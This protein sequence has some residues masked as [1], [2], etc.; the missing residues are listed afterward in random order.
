M[1]RVISP[2]ESIPCRKPGKQ[3]VYSLWLGNNPSESVTSD[4][5]GIAL[6]FTEGQLVQLPSFLG[7]QLDSLSEVC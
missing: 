7:F 2:A 3:G 1:R 5:Q 4:T 6:V